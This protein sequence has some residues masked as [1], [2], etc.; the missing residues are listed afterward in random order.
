MDS[1]ADLLRL[2]PDEDIKLI[3]ELLS[4]EVR[5]EY[6]CK[7]IRN[8][9]GG[10]QMPVPHSSLH[11]SRQAEWPWVLRSGDFFAQNVL[12]VG[13]SWTVLKYTI[14]RRCNKLTSLETNTDQDMVKAEETIS[15]LGFDNI[16]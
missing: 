2:P 5:C 8:Q 7:L 11:W 3:R 1:Y 16:Q 10:I 9:G 14:A 4:Y 13:G 15:R 6:S 12:E